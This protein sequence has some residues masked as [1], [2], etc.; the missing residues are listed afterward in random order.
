MD[1]PPVQQTTLDRYIVQIINRYGW[2]R[3]PSRIIA[4]NRVKKVVY[5]GK[6]KYCYYQCERCKEDKFKS[7]DMEV[8]HKEARINPKYGWQGLLVYVA[9]TFVTPD[10]LEV[11]C[12]SCHDKETKEQNV[13]RKKAH[14]KREFSLRRKRK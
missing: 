5:V 6:R 9:R 12:K 11:L 10:K 14:G 2:V 7:H 4:L 3:F 13:E 8:H 1:S